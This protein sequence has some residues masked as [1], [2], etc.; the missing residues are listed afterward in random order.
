MSAIEP[1]RPS[2]S[3]IS[4]PR[5]AIAGLR[6]EARDATGECDD[7]FVIAARTPRGS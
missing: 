5:A 1:S 2:G 7:L 6:I 4:D 3:V